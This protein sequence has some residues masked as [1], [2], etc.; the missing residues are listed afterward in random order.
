MEKTVENYLRDTVRAAGGRA[1][2]FIS[3][4]WTG[5]PDRLVLLPGGRM[6]FAET[7]DRGKYPRANQRRAHEIL[8]SLGFRV[9]VPKTR[10][11]V[12]AM[13]REVQ[14]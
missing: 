4:G 2:K 8:R 7:K 1:P 11:D 9:Y 3:P 12:D 6:C 10:A 14:G 5:V 13:M